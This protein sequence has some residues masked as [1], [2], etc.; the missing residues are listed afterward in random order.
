MWGGFGISMRTAAAAAPYIF[1]ESCLNIVLQKRANIVNVMTAHSN[2]LKF[3]IIRGC[4]QKLTET[5]HTHTKTANDKA[6]DAKLK[7]R[8]GSSVIANGNSLA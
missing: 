1:L 3:I 6:T 5:R 2:K 4:E 8:L 7:L